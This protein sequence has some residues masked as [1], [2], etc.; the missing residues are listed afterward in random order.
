MERI[1]LLIGLFIVP[2]W[3]LWLGHRLRDRTA[4]GR[5]AF[6]GGVIGHSSALVI[7]LVALHFPPVLW[8]GGARS[9]V[10]FWAMLI[11][12]IGGA[13]IGAMRARETDTA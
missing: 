4:A 2:G 9:L 6:W 11:G 8:T 10:A 5:G 1:A 12:G 13:A 3:L 7:A